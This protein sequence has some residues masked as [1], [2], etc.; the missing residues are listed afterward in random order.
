MCNARSIAWWWWWW[1]VCVCV[2]VRVCVC[3]GARAVGRAAFETAR[4]CCT[5]DEQGVLPHP[6]RE[7]CEELLENSDPVSR[8]RALAVGLSGQAPVPPHVLV[9]SALAARGV[10][11]SHSAAGE[12]GGVEAGGGPPRAGPY[13]ALCAQLKKQEA[14]LHMQGEVWACEERVAEGVERG[15]TLL[16]AELFS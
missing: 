15:V 8:L 11:V 6:W 16:A 13:L 2:C 1:C 5:D 9:T 7:G 4:A 3:W 14:D 10:G 12:G